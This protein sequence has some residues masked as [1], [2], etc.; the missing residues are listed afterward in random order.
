[1][2]RDVGLEEFAVGVGY[3]IGP[4]MGGVLFEYCGFFWA[5]FP[6][7]VFYLG[8]YRMTTLVVWSGS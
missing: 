8:Q 4:A 6:L 2:Q 1:M 3:M 7:S 5:F